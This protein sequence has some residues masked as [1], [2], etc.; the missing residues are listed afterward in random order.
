MSWSTVGTT[1]MATWSLPF[2]ARYG[3]YSNVFAAAVDVDVT[4]S[5]DRQC[6]AHLGHEVAWV[7]REVAATA[8]LTAR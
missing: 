7:N 6:R 1:T 4:F 2:S 5:E 3:S 8:E